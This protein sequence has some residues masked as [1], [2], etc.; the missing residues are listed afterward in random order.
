MI[1]CFTIIFKS[2]L[3]LL[4]TGE[5]VNT[6]IYFYKKITSRKKKKSP[7]FIKRSEDYKWV[8]RLCHASGILRCMNLNK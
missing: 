1:V 8:R 7:L 6:L 3:E 2:A 5:I 4:Y